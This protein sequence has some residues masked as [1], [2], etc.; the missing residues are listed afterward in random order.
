MQ[1]PSYVVL[2]SGFRALDGSAIRAG[3]RKAT[4]PE[5]SPEP[6]HNAPSPSGTI[7]WTFP[8]PA[9]T[10]PGAFL[11][12]LPQTAQTLPGTHCKSTFPEPPQ[13]LAETP[14]AFCCWSKSHQKAKV[15]STEDGPIAFAQSSALSSNNG[16]MAYWR[17]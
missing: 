5:P 14:I 13:N 3:N 11:G 4:F 6:A 9:A 8:E 1:D 2:Q 12:T 10:Q 15:P 17:M 16:R 7:P